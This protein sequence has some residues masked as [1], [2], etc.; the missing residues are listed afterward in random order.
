MNIDE[1]KE[2]VIIIRSFLDKE[3]INQDIVEVDNKDLISYLEKIGP[4]TIQY[5]TGIVPQLESFTEL[6]GT[7]DLWN[8]D[9][10]DI[11]IIKNYQIKRLFQ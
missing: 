8:K 2:K 6:G 11:W 3:Q 1:I 4:H 10:N 5:E 9:I 7:V